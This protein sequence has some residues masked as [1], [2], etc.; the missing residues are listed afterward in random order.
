MVTITKQETKL[1]VSEKTYTHKE[2]IKSL[3][4]IWN[5]DLKVW[6]V[7][8]TPENLSV[9]KGLKQKRR[10]GYCGEVGHFRPKCEKWISES[11]KFELDVAAEKR[12]KPGWRY[13]K[14]ADARDDCECGIVDRRIKHLDLTVQEPFTCWGCKNYCC[15]T[16]EVC[17]HQHGYF[18]F[19]RNY[20]CPIHPL[21]YEER[22]QQKFMNDSSG[23]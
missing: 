3:G 7:R 19:E 20:K 21:T 2:T 10:C 17:P 9:L 4:G 5:P 12:A 18:P 13:K 11:R 22:E 8:N 1:H 14:F 6:V 15:S 16:V 23:T